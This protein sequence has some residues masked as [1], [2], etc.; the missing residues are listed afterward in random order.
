[1]YLYVYDD[2]RLKLHW[3][4]RRES[5]SWGRESGRRFVSGDGRS[6]GRVSGSLTYRTVWPV[7][8]GVSGPN[9]GDFWDVAESLFRKKRNT[10]NTLNF[11][12]NNEHNQLYR[13]ISSTTVW[14]S[15]K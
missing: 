6:R 13:Y 1:M 3:S 2:W 9:I 14:L 15:I 12:I 11:V 8:C 4:L 5:T 10:K 7:Q